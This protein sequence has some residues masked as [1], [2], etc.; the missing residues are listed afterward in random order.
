MI[1]A[2]QKF[3]DTALGRVCNTVVR[4]I[5]G[6]YVKMK[7]QYKKTV[8]Y[9]VVNPFRGVEIPGHADIIGTLA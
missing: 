4:G 9:H 6:P 2:V 8:G 5:P 3:S 7:G 1:N